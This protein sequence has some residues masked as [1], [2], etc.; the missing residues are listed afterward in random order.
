MRL[1][2]FSSLVLLITGFAQL[3]LAGNPPNFSAEYSVR[4]GNFE[5][6]RATVTLRQDNNNYEYRS[7]SEPSGVV[8]VFA[9]DRV[10]Q[11]SKGAIQ[12]NRFVPT[13]FTFLHMKGKK[14]KRYK[15]TQFNWS[16]NTVR[17][18]LRGNDNARCCW[19]S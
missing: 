1:F 13:S 16:N 7:V 6:G 9:S 12:N 18:R 8:A 11:T 2:K 19:T 5:A 3:A 14:R 15:T 10:T 4:R 17:Y